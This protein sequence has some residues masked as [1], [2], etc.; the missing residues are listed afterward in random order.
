MVTQAIASHELDSSP[1]ACCRE[2]D[3]Q[4][5]IGYVAQ[6]KARFSHDRRVYEEFLY[7]LRAFR[8]GQMSRPEVCEVIATLF[9]D[10]QDLLRGFSIFLPD[11]EQ[12][13]LYSIACAAKITGL[14]V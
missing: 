7:S 5:A 9:A 1:S 4:T 13:M 2:P 10:Q 3:F 8:D 12:P 14:R 11:E 6:V